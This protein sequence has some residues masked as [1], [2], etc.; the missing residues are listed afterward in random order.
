[1]RALDVEVRRPSDS[2]ATLFVAVE[3]WDAGLYWTKVHQDGCFAPGARPRS[4]AQS[5][6]LPSPALRHRPVAAV[7]RNSTSPSPCWATVGAFTPATAH[8]FQQSMVDPSMRYPESSFATACNV[9]AL[10]HFTTPALGV[11]F[12][13]AGS[14][15]SVVGLAPVSSAWPA[16]GVLAALVL[17]ALGTDVPVGPVELPEQPEAESRTATAAATPTTRIRIDPSLTSVARIVP[18]RVLRRSR[19]MITLV[20]RTRTRIDL[21]NSLLRLRETARVT[22]SPW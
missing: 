22:V 18:V 13:P 8:C 3:S 12:C 19:S 5:K 21:K 10:G 7:C 17:A 20:I 11:A 9:A 6:E 1:L 14:T 2:T 16:A 15:G 4:A